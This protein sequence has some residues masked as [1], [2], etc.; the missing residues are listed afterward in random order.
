MNEKI[1]TFTIGSED[2]DA[3]RHMNNARY[4]V[5]F[6]AARVEFFN[7]TGFSVDS[8]TERGLGFFIPK[9]GPTRYFRQT[10]EGDFLTIT[11]K[12]QKYDG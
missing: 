11:T 3:N 10:F 6:D 7:G 9:K 12:F 1:H 4:N 2:I 8:L 5:H